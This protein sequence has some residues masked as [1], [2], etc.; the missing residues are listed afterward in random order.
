[1]RIAQA[2]EDEDV[3]RCYVHRP[4][5]PDELFDK[6]IDISPAHSAALDLGCGTGKIAHGLASSFSRICAVDPSEAMLSIAK[7][8]LRDSPSNIT[9]LNETAESADFEGQPFDLV[10]AGSSIHWM[11]QATV[12]PRLSEAVNTKH[13]FA[14]VDGDAAYQPSWKDEYNDFTTH[15]M[16]RLKQ[17]GRFDERAQFGSWQEFKNR[18]RRFLDVSDETEIISQPLFQTVEDYILCEHSRDTWAKSKLGSL[19]EEF[20]QELT[21]VL[22]PYAKDGLLT[23][24]MRT[25][26]AWG[27]IRT[28]PKA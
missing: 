23:F 11:D 14:V 8:L 12:F 17:M 24:R 21:S 19:S 28:G 26:L 13:T 7:S 6:L 10:V 27:S 5:Y 2:F 20:D 9:W 22:R 1:M 4:P 3:A 18:H 25:R 16:A 15:W